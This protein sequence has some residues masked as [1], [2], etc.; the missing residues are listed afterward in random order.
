MRRVDKSQKTFLL[1]T[2]TAISYGPTSL[3]ARTTGTGS[4]WIGGRG[5]N[6]NSSTDS[7]DFYFFKASGASVFFASA[8]FTF[9]LFLLVGDRFVVCAR[10]AG[11]LSIQPGGIPGPGR[12]LTTGSEGR[13]G[14][15][16]TAGREF[17]LPATLH[18]Q[19]RSV[20]YF[21]C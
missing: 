11:A 2:H 3:A 5:G 18:A 4:G 6:S 20:W 12:H 7:S 14:R 10:G 13:T 16:C 8:P 1:H 17:Q 9:I 21:L 19:H 15:P